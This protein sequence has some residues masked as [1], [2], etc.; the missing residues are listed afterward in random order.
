MQIREYQGGDEQAQAEV[1]NLAA[2]CLPA[3]KPAAAEEIARRYR[4]PDAN[5]MGR[6]YAIERGQLAGYVVFN[7]SGRI[8]YPWCR[9]KAQHIRSQL[10]EVALNAMRQRGFDEA[11]AAYR[12]DWREV[13]GFLGQ[14]GFRRAREMINYV[15]EP[16]GLPHTIERPGT[17]IAP[18]L[19]ADLPTVMR[20]G[21]GLFGAETEGELAAFLLENPYFEAKSAYLLRRAETDQILGAAV[22]LADPLFADPTKIDPAMPCFRLGALGTETERHKRVN[23]LF[24]CVFDSVAAAESLLAEAVRRFEVAGLT[25]AAAQAPSDQPQLCAFY[26]RY[27]QRQGSFPI[28]ARHLDPTT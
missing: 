18:L 15:G 21:C 6:F 8:S 25:H 26:D 13:L 20:L 16:A 7:P 10:L 24:S 17:I 23:G 9:P 2:A 28:L 22:A 12:S 4:S 19:K 3:F 1:Y 27:F 11:W 5:G 14:Q